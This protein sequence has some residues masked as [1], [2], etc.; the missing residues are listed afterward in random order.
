MAQKTSRRFN[1]LNAIE[2][3]GNK[4]PDP[5]LL[6]VLGA[7]LVMVLSHVG[8]IWEWSVQP[9]RPQ[10]IAAV[11]GDGA[12]AGAAT[13]RR[14]RIELV[15]DGE[16]LR[17]VTLLDSAGLFWALSSMV[18]NFINFA[19]LGIV[20][21]GMLGIGVAER[22][23]LFGAVL[24]FLA[25]LVPGKLL[26]PT[27]VFLGILSSAAMDAGYVV[28]PPLAAA[29]YL[30]MGRP[31]LAGIAAVFAGVSAGFSANLMVSG[32]DAL[33][34]GITTEAARIIEPEYIVSAAA[35]WWFIIIST[36]VL[37][38]TGWF[39]TARFVEPRL[40]TRPAN[41]GGPRAIS[42]E[43]LD[44]QRLTSVEIRGLVWA[45]AALAAFLGIVLLAVFIP[46]APL[47]GTGIRMARWVEAIVPLIFFFFLIPGIAYGLAT[48]TI[49]SSKDVAK[50]MIESMAAMAPIIV[51]AF[52]AAQ[53]VEYFNHSNLGRMLAMAGGKAL[54]AANLGPEL[55]II[56]FIGLIMLLNL[57][58]GSM[59]AKYLMVAPIFVP[60]LMMLG[61]SPELTQAAY[62]VGDSVTNVI[63]PLNA[64]LIIILVVIQRYARDAGMGT[65]V[66][67][68]MPYSI[69]FGIVWTIML[70]LWMASGR[71]LGPESPLWYIPA[72]PEA[73]EAAAQ[74]ALI[75]A[76]LP[77]V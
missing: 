61:I 53:F 2:W 52:F 3:V 20:L 5:A 71:E 26:T 48:S 40:R 17:P 56:V 30:T 14:P 25:S 68:M 28:L 47:H 9:V 67:L 58:M 33:A 18:K 60:M 75:L 24:R 8:Y 4:L 13:T 21:T 49:S 51:L 34:A 11:D 59:S 45:A 19:P 72:A 23:G 44:A 74:S 46:G 64:Y 41:E 57:F 73:A 15:P 76:Q 7:L 1:P 12:A 32:I 22:V 31:P 27:M 36:A 54:F 10:V 38:L 39:V 50:A 77:V 29:L 16:P 6:F 63:T 69:A 43:E 35:N 37:T 66:A 62:R 42:R 65:L 70:L 55:L